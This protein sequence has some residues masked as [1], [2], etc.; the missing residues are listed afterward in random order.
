MG[1]YV[2]NGRSQFS[3]TFDQIHKVVQHLWLVISL[4]PL[5]VE[6]H[7]TRTNQVHVQR[8][9]LC[10]YYVVLHFDFQQSESQRTKCFRAWLVHVL[11]IKRTMC[12]RNSI[13]IVTGT[14]LYHTKGPCK[15][16]WLFL[17][18]I[19]TEQGLHS[20]IWPLNREQWSPGFVWVFFIR[21]GGWKTTASC[22]G[23]TG[24]TADWKTTAAGFT[25]LCW[26]TTTALK[27]EAEKQ[28]ILV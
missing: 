3:V 6:K 15:T 25:A 14:R 9:R 10:V 27:S 19:Q 4:W 22:W 17:C 13:L 11:I 1:P 26:S 28:K 18:I 12:D 8:T 24:L 21:E 20:W 5:W 23:H 2:L 16:C 7:H